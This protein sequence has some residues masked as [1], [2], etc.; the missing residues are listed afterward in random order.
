MRLLGFEIRFD[1]TWLILVALIV[2][3]LS[4]GLFPATFEDLPTST[5][6]WMGVLGAVGLFASIFA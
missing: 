3:S 6:I 2:W 4:A 5:Y 1:L